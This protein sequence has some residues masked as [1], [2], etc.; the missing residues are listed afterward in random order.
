MGRVPSEAVPGDIV[1]IFLG[2][3][4]PHVIRDDGDGYFKLVGECYMHGT[5]DGEIMTR[6]DLTLQDFKLR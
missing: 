4:V 2:A 3:S 6:E 5:I 1:C